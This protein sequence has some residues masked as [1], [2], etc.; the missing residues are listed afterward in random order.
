MGIYCLCV[1]T[2]LCIHIHVVYTMYTLRVVISYYFQYDRAYLVLKECHR[3]VPKDITI[4]LLQAKLCYDRLQQVCDT[5]VI[6]L[7]VSVTGYYLL[8]GCRFLVTP[9]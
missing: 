7:S 1:Y 9:A 8:D 3:L 4:L 2:T 5:L 6:L